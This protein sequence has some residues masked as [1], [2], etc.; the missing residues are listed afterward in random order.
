MSS[1]DFLQYKL[2]YTSLRLCLY[3]FLY[4]STLAYSQ[5]GLAVRSSPQEHCEYPVKMHQN[6]LTVVNRGSARTQLHGGAYDAP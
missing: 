3:L 6:P 1:S 2:V 4:F 5:S